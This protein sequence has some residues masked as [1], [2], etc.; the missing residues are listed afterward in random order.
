MASE[1]VLRTIALA[2]GGEAVAG[3]AVAAVAACSVDAFRVAL[4]H[5][6][7]LTLIDICKQKRVYFKRD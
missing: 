1:R 4:A 7:V 3:L 5:G 2:G 6:P